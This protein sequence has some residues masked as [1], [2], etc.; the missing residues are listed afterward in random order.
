MDLALN[1]NPRAATPLYRQLCSELRHSILSGRLHAG[2]RVPSSRALAQSLGISRATVMQSYDQLISEGYL[3]TVMGSGT[4]ISRQLPEEA[5]RAEPGGP[6]ARHVARRS[7]LQL[8]IFG[9]SLMCV[10]REPEL[11]LPYNFRYCRPA[12]DHFPL[13]QW[14]RL[15]S[16]QYRTENITNLSYAENGCGEPTLRHAIAGY[17]ARARAVRCAPEQILMVNGSQQALSLIAQVLLNRGDNAALEEPG[18]QGARHAFQVQGAKLLPVKVDE[19]GVMPT[20]LPARGAKLLYVTPSHQFPTGAVLPLSRRLELLQW[21]QTTGTWLIEDDYDSEFRYDSRPFPSLQGLASGEQVLYVGTFSKV[22]FPALRIGYLVVPPALTQVFEKA[23]WVQ[24]RHNPTLEQRA[25]AEFISEGYFERHLRRMRRL[26]DQ[27]RQTLV[28]ALQTHFGERVTILGA[29]SGMHLMIRLQTRLS[30]SAIIERAASAGVG[31]VSASIYYLG[32][33]KGNE[34]VL[35]Y[36]SL[37]ERKIQEGIRRLA[38][39][40][41]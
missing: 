21:A 28:R 1:L 23:K 26:Y 3:E 38:K 13:A 5:L 6:S 19:C 27:R 7:E 12:V 37:S 14:R 16:R 20:A 32:H 11:P 10:E 41:E 25:L 33:G 29:N 17:L 9:E 18:Y 39:A 8:S 34:F 24:D 30:E 22:L 40:L 4:K 35:G 2:A 15:L 36:A 31:I